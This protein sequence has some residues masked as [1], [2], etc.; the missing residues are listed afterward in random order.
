MPIIGRRGE[1]LNYNEAVA[2]VHGLPRFAKHPGV[3]NTTMLL[4]RLNN[5]E[6]T[7]KFVHVAG[8]NGKGS[9]TM[10][11]SSVL[12]QAGYK[13]GTTI[14]PY[15]I[16]FCERFLINCELASEEKVAKAL[17]AVKN[18]VVESDRIV[19]FD[20][21]TAAAII[22]FSWEKCDI[23]C[24][25]TGLGGRLDS[26]NAVKNT[27]V[28]CITAIGKDH[29]EYL[30]DT[31]DKIAFEK[32][33]I[34]KNNCN[35][36][37]Y[38]K[39]EKSAFDVIE[40]TAEKC[41]CTLTV[42]NIDNLRILQIKNLNNRNLILNG[43]NASY[44]NINLEV[45]FAGE[46]Q[47]YNATVACE[48]AY[49][50]KKHGFFISD[51]NITTGIKNTK[52]PARIEILSKN[53]L[54]ILDG[55]H[56]AQG[57]S[58]LAKTLESAGCNNLIGLMGVLKNKGEDEMMSAL[59]PLF[60]SV[61]TINPDEKRGLSAKK[62]ASVAEKYCDDVLPCDDVETALQTALEKAKG[63]GTGLVICGS[64]YL[65]AKARGILLAQNI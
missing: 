16:N 20:A 60:K 28:A 33:G 19:E 56:N 40:K 55:S 11:V 41:G 49:A 50:L 64:L 2:W 61:Y 21:V 59:C 42:P 24:L 43:S 6:K 45:P 34:F 26:S 3:E 32:C 44:N 48:A 1:T 14:S 35:V 53:P 18:V 51:D 58:A 54:V 15:V 30:G 25:E 23:V 29:I 57:A 31:L 22:L 62:L 7:L 36:I 46:H 38:P 47:I 8:T 13:V 9:V 12:K 5:P 52:F 27:L 17:T 39:Q 65:A 4:N 10:M 37:S 63:H